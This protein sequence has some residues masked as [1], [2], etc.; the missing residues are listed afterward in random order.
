MFR[1]TLKLYETIDPLK[2]YKVI[3]TILKVLNGST[4]LNDCTVN[5]MF[6]IILG[7]VED[8]SVENW[9]A[10]P[11]GVKAVKLSPSVYI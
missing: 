4:L 1:V 5:D 11:I 8:K 9:G 3:F 7:E 6:D 10:L 2:K